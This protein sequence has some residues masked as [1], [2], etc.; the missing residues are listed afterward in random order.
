MAT[1]DFPTVHVGIVTYNS[2]AELPGCFDAL[3]AQTYPNLHIVAL[4]NASQDDSV[5]WLKNHVSEID[6]EC[7]INS[8]NVGFA[9]AH[10]HI[11]RHCSIDS[12]EFYL[13]LNPDVRLMPNYVTHLVAAL[14][15]HQA[16]WGTGK[17]YSLNDQD[18]LTD[19]IYSAGH[20]ILRGGY[21]FH[22]G[23]EEPDHDQYD[24]GRPVFGAPGAAALYSGLLIHDISTNGQFFDEDMFMYGEDVD[25]DWRA[26]R[27]GWSCRYTPDAIAYHRGSN[28]GQ[29]L[30]S[31]ALA[32]RYLSVLKNAGLR[33]L[34][35]YNFPLIGFHCALRLILSPCYGMKIIQRLVRYG[36]RKLSQRSPASTSFDA[37]YW[38]NWSRQQ[39]TAQP[40]NT[41]E[42]IRAYIDRA[43]GRENRESEENTR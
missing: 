10:N 43:I 7:L 33:S 12:T 36:P 31:H 8:V 13:A 18:E 11:I 24:I 39:S 41:W 37:N 15:H 4:D 26:Q 28:P 9:C 32:N 34:I 30:R 6:I 29:D 17:I 20:A 23:Y 16:N 35:L 22:I 14:Q 25:V 1:V 3:A 42:R 38:F 40:R 27:R 21:A 2:R 19:L 5:D